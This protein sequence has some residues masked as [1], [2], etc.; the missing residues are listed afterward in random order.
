MDRDGGGASPWLWGRAMMHSMAELNTPM[1]QMPRIDPRE[2][3]K[4]AS[5][6]Q[7]FQS[8]SKAFQFERVGRIF[9]AMQRLSEK[10]PQA[11]EPDERELFGPAI[12]QAKQLASDAAS[13]ASELSSKL[14]LPQPSETEKQSMKM[15]L[16]ALAERLKWDTE[17]EIV[18][19]NEAAF[20][21]D[22]L[23]AVTEALGS[24]GDVVDVPVSR[25]RDAP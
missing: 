16:A 4:L 24:P 2:L 22:A 20:L 6:L 18:T 7:M 1:S 5:W 10:Q 14:A 17:N 15:L 12:A 3:E 19:P 13:T 11:F 25:R 8:R 9:T 23:T 21:G